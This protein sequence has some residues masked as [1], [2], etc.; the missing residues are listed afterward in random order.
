MNKREKRTNQI[1]DLE[2][3]PNQPQPLRGRNRR[4]ETMCNYT[5]N[6]DRADT[7]TIVRKATATRVPLATGACQ[8]CATR[9]GSASPQGSVIN[10]PNSES[11]YYRIEVLT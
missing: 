3:Q 9:I 5:R 6:C 4:T 8:S 1:G 7:H 11:K 10:Q 2:K